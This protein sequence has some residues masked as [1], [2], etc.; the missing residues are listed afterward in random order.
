MYEEDRL[1]NGDD[2]RAFI[3]RIIADKSIEPTFRAALRKL[4]ISRLPEVRLTLR[5]LHAYGFDETAPHCKCGKCGEL[6]RTKRP[7]LDA[8]ASDEE[9]KRAEQA[10][11][12]TL[13]RTAQG[14]SKTEIGRLPNRV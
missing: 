9:L 10:A 8:I 11:Q 7:L 12:Q 2:W 14:R 6:A 4:Y 5:V 3:R 1:M 13:A